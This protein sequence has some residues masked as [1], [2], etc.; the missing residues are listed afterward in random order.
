MFVRVLT[1][2]DVKMEFKVLG[3]LELRVAG[4]ENISVSPQLWTVLV[5]L[6]LVPGM[7]IQPETLI[8][9][10]WGDNP[11]RKAKTTIRSY[12]SRLDRLL[13]QAQEG[14]QAPTE[15]T[16]MTAHGEHA[17]RVTRVAGGYALMIDPDTVDLHR[18]RSLKRKSDALADSGE[19]WNAADLLQEAEALWRGKALAGL[20]GDWIAGIRNTI[21]EEHRSA[22]NRRIELGLALGRHAALLA[23]LATLVEQHPLDEELTAHQMHA[24]F[25]TGRQADALRA[26]REM[27]ARLASLGLEPTPELARLHLRILQHDP[28]LAITPAYRRNGR[29]PQPDTL[30]ADVGDFLGRDAELRALTE[31]ASSGDR[32]VIWVIEGMGGIGKTALAVHAARR[33]AQRY[34]DAHLY[35]DF[36]THDEHRE[37]LSP[38]DA[39]GEML[40]MLGI[41]AIRMPRTPQARADLW[42]TELAGRRAVL[43]FDDVTGPEQIGP[44]IP[45]ATDSLIIVTSREHH[46]IWGGARTLT[47]PALSEDDAAEL[48]TQIA[49][50][51]VDRELEHVAKACQ[52][53]AYLPL[54]IRLAA[55]RLRSG[56]VSNLSSLA[57][58]LDEL[59]RSAA[60][61]GL[62]SEVGERVRASFEL[63]YR[64]LTAGHQRFFRY[65]GISPCLDMTVHS[66]ARLANVTLAESAAALTALASHHLL[67]ETS[68]GRFG[69]HD[70]LR[71]FAAHHFRDEES[72]SEI[73]HAVGRLAD[74]Y[75]RTI[76]QANDVRRAGDHEK[77]AEDRAEPNA[78]PF[79]DTPRA[80]AAWLESESANILRVAEQCARHEYK[81]RCAEIAHRLGEFLETS[82]HWDDALTAHLMALQACRDTGD[83]AGTARAAFDLSEIYMRTGHTKAALQHAN[84]AAVA[85]GMLRDNLH[86]AA[87]LDRIGTIHCLTARFRGALAYHQEALEI[88]REAGD[89]RGTARAL[90]NAGAALWY[91]GRLQE[92]MSYLHQAMDI[93]RENN[94]LRS[95]AA[96]L[97][98][99]G[100]VQHHQGYHRDAMRSYQA[101]REIS[102]MIGE[103][104][105]LTLSNHNIAEV[106]SYKGN[107]DVAIIALREVL[108]TY[109]SLGDPQHQAY[110][111]ADIGA[112]YQNTQRFDEALALYE[113]SAAMAEL[114]DDRYA[115]AEAL[116]G[117]AE[118]HLN[119][120]RMDTA[121]ET[122]EQAARLAGEIETLYLKA[123]AYN[124]MAEI[125]LHTRGTEAARIYWREAYDIFS[126]IGVPEAATVGF[127]LQTLDTLS[128]QAGSGF[129]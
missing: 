41:P 84:E 118:A 28:E 23:E 86:R 27:H 113:K 49:G 14:H 110:A 106:E 48:F 22:T 65:L 31:E 108:A 124:G 50:R 3:P 101:S 96:L 5:N 70:L 102:F 35:L 125:V 38:A 71:A 63:S 67:E 62:A 129:R 58:E 30:P 34:P 114:A 54:A 78:M 4:R 94:D 90:I 47:L 128:P 89:K 100:T 42:S 111:L 11:P 119:S 29:E 116:C 72:A 127:R 92:E 103:R 44:L 91:L 123:K 122:Y 81:Q 79:E 46:P 8:R 74:Y 51:A 6:L 19:A 80:A 87:A 95:Q 52:L 104:Q 39:I 60:D 2:A 59:G 82:G 18:F 17:T 117:M 93:F 7:A 43:I 97:N 98:N 25:R 77:P 88:Y 68:E 109:R 61:R 37:P 66:G 69:L 53:C 36:R 10:L 15:A 40:A 26:Y 75:L 105:N 107:Y 32:P 20:S 9:H 21:E 83:P 64:R 85:F 1:G 12:I 112:V 56:E 16:R 33:M 99:I 55:S 24:L 57:D 73:R 126:Q 121:L 115:F 76:N 120:G 45:S 13:S